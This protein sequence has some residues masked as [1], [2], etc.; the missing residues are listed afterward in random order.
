MLVLRLVLNLI[1]TYYRVVLT[2][3]K[4]EPNR[5]LY[6]IGRLPDSCVVS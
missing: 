2:F 1:V 5:T 4:V 3:L 6:A